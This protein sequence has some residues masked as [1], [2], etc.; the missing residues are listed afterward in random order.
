MTTI[1]ASI[2]TPTVTA[3]RRWLAPVVAWVAQF[4]TAVTALIRQAGVRPPIPWRRDGS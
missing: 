3:R 2:A 4:G 1:A